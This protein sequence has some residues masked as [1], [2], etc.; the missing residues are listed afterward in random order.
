MVAPTLSCAVPST[1]D[2][3]C[4]VEALPVQLDYHSGT[5][6]APLF[7][8]GAE[9]VDLRDR[10]MLQSS[11]SAV[12]S[13][14]SGDL[15]LGADAVVHSAVAV[16][17]S[18]ELRDRA[19]L[20]GDAQVTG[21]IRL[22][23]AATISGSATSGSPPSD[24]DAPSWTV[25]F[26]TGA[27]PSV[28]LEPGRA[29]TLQPGQYDSVIVKSRSTLTLARGQYSIRSLDLEPDAVLQGA[30]ESGVV[31]LAVRDSLIW[32]GSVAAIAASE[33]SLTYAGEGDAYVEA[34]FNGLLVAP[35]AS[36]TLRSASPGH[37]GVFWARRL[38]I[39]AGTQVRYTS[40]TGWGELDSAPVLPA[41][42]SISD[43]PASAGVPPT[44]AP[45]AAAV[46]A[47]LQWL[48]LST[49]SDEPAA[50]SAIDV[51]A[52]RDDIAQLIIT[53]FDELKNT[54]RPSA[55]VA[56]SALGYLR[57]PSSEAFYGSLLATALPQDQQGVDLVTGYMV[58]AVQGLGY[59]Q[60]RSADSSLLSLMGQHPSRRVRKEAVRVYTH[61]QPE[62]VRT[63]AL[64]HV[65]ADE[66]YFLDRFENRVW[67]GEP[68]FDAKLDTY[69]AKHP[70]TQQ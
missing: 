47:F 29:A 24:A 51:V 23:N 1:A 10:S 39:D 14:Y 49:P 32:R 54:D 13:A 43:T 34:P 28:A 38:V 55:L 33:F 50:R 45:S 44:L 64:A 57:A 18:L 40:F 30:G 7:I 3:S 35:R 25:K 6:V 9:G 20:L 42:P 12:V 8:G 59:L 66:R 37:S 48:N 31:A 53:R 52:R 26:S 58:L 4:P 46:N 16:G 68:D 17:G 2:S 36:L 41:L 22:G 60:T 62:A 56:L 5:L 11:N 21:S 69:L 15:T 19:T 70:E 65:R 67:E 63:A 61:G 27:L